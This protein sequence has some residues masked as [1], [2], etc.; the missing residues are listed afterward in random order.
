MADRDFDVA[1]I[2]AGPGGYVCAIRCAQLGLRTACVERR[3]ALGGTCLNVGCIP[4]KALLRSSEL[5]ERARDD[6][7]RRGV[8]VAG[9]ELDLPA[10]MANKDKTVD[11]LTR[12]IAGLFRKNGVT[13]LTGTARLAGAHAI[14]VDGEP[15]TADSIVIA[16]GSE[17]AGLP[18]VDIDE[19][20]VVSSTGALSLAEAPERL[21]VIGGGYI[22]LELGSVWRRLG[23]RVVV[24]E[25]LD[26]I[27]PGM[28]GEIAREFRKILERQG[29]A[30]R[31]GAKV[32]GVEASGKAIEVVL[33]SAGGGKDAIAC[34][35]VL[36]AVGRRPRTEG[37]GLAE[38]G[39]E[40]DGRGHIAVD[41]RFATGVPGIYAI[42]DCVGGAM[43]AHKA[44]DEG[45]A[46]AEIVAGRAGRVNYGVVPSVVYTDPEAASVGETEEDLKARGADYRIGR[47]PMLANSR[48]RTY[49]ETAGMAK[50]LADAATDRVLGVHVLAAAA[51]ELIAEAAVAMEFGASAEDLARTCHAHP[52]FSEAVR[53][54]AL[55]VDGRAIH[56]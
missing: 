49:G 8:K 18:G 46:V 31:L 21:V 51:G 1:V 52:T 15:V 50:V 9:V 10:M 35:T 48:A 43:L 29:L 34:D 25:A 11:T 4:S 32:A 23:S 27:A 16:T 19:T 20:R 45:I 22:G 53:E 12:G 44:E 3:D 17:A 38:A 40:T 47:F 14:D 5:Y 55:A 39:V 41:G 28:D 56:V 30:F 7:G 13:R 42:G 36:M 2:G 6:L 33:E 54:A 24:V 26:R 37:L